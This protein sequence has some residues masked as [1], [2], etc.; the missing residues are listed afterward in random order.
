MVLTVRD[1]DEW[2]DSMER[3]F[4]TILDW[5]SWK[6][7]AFIN[8][9]SASIL[10]VV[11]SDPN[12]LQTVRRYTSILHLSLVKWTD[13]DWENRRK[14]RA[15][16]IKHN[17]YVRAHV[18]E[19]NLLVFQAEQGWEPL[20]NFLGKPI[21]NGPYPRVNEGSYAADLHTPIFW[22]KWVTTLLGLLFWPGLIGV[23]MAVAWYFQKFRLLVPLLFIPPLFRVRR[24]FTGPSKERVLVHK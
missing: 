6:V 17:D 13:G 24:L 14:L 2:V 15:G 19:S 16:F 5:N 3:V 10:F 12:L 1:P 4:Y 23:S 9:V 21:P 8:P 20:C 22:I 11:M 7:L 18:T